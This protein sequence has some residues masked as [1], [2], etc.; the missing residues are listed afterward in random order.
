VEPHHIKRWNDSPELRYDP[1]NGI[2]LCRPHH[3]KT[4]KREHLFEEYFL[5]IISKK[6]KLDSVI[7]LPFEEIIPKPP[8]KIKVIKPK[9]IRIRHGYEV[10]ITWEQANEIRKLHELGDSNTKIAS[11]Y[12]VDQTTI[13]R[14]VNGK[15][16]TKPT[17]TRTY[18]A[19]DHH[20]SQVSL[21]MT[22]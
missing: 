10:K 7:Q 9:K 22:Q 12:G 3:Y 19:T 14:I 16:R 21:N 2:T 6:P 15:R 8:I 18:G 5:N 11:D 13:S 17:L 1:N 20:Q 4:R